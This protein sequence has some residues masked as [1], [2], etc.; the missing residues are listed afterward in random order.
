MGN[1]VHRSRCLRSYRQ[2]HAFP[3]ESP[4]APSSPLRGL[5]LTRTDC[6]DMHHALTHQNCAGTCNHLGTPLGWWTC[7]GRGGAC[8]PKDV[9]NCKAHYIKQCGCG[10][11]KAKWCRWWDLHP[12][13]IVGVEPKQC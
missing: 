10:P 12:H 13:C 3:C 2:R 9:N 8:S 11:R 4:K 7:E 5:S 1:T 6:C